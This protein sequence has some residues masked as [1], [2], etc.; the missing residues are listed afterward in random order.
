MFLIARLWRRIG[1]TWCMRT[2]WW[3]TVSPGQGWSA[4]TTLGHSV[5]GW[6][7]QNVRHS[8]KQSLRMNVAQLLRM[9]VTSWR[10]RSARTSLR[11]SARLLIPRRYRTNVNL[12]S[13]TSVM[14][15]LLWFP[16]QKLWRLLKLS[17]KKFLLRNA[18]LKLL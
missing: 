16:K 5:L 18:I 7:R 9:T 10:R 14:I 6:R 12:L 1:A 11:M 3:M 8:M 2:C 15:H 17:V 4:R 13:G